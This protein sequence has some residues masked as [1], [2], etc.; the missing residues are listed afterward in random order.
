VIAEACLHQLSQASDAERRSNIDG[1]GPS[2]QVR[3]GT[4]FLSTLASLAERGV[5]GGTILGGGGDG[6]QTEATPCC[7]PASRA[8]GLADILHPHRAL[9]RTV[10]GNGNSLVSSR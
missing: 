4:L 6:Q 2:E 1:C 9:F 5:T 3:R 8:R 10:C 7:N